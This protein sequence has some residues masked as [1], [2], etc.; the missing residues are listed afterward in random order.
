V[1]PQLLSLPSR[2]NPGSMDRMMAVL[3]RRFPLG[4]INLEGVHRREG[5]VVGF[6]E[7][8]LSLEHRQ[9]RVSVA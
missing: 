6:L 2:G 4:G 7:K 1:I 3:L 5:H 8:C 9:R